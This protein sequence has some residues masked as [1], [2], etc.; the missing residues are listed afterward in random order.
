MTLTRE[1]RASVDVRV[2]RRGLS[3]GTDLNTHA[4]RLG[5]L[6]GLIFIVALVTPAA[7]DQRR[8]LL[9]GTRR[10]P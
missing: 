5:F 9:A 6:F 10:N 7:A 1:A 4:S 3:E 8:R 2:S